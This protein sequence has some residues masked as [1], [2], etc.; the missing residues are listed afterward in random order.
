[1]I[2]APTPRRRVVPTSQFN[3]Q[4]EN[5][6]G[7]GYITAKPTPN[8]RIVAY[9]DIEEERARSAGRPLDP[10]PASSR[11]R[12]ACCPDSA[13][14]TELLLGATYDRTV[15]DRTATGALGWSHTFGYRNVLNA[16]VFA[17]GFKRDSDE[18]AFVIFD[19]ALVG[20]LAGQQT[21]ETSTEQQ[22]YMGAVNHTYGIDDLTIRYGLEAGALDF[23]HVDGFDV[24]QC[25]STSH[26]A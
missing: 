26:P 7:T 3:L 6:S 19:T 23:Q 9:F 4:F 15:D 24:R 16:A 14:S 5:I 25:V 8:D 20:M 1:M 2:S 21:I 18:S 17:S 10:G 13:R 22:T 11:S 12:S